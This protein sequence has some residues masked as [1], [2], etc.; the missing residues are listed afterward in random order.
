[1]LPFWI[2]PF[3]HYKIVGKE[4]LKEVKKTGVVITSNHVHLTDAPLLATRL[5]G[6]KRKV[7]IVMLSENMDIPVAGPFME[8]LGCV[9]LGDT[10]SGMKNFNAH[11]NSLLQKKKP[12]LIFP[13]TALWPYYRKIRPFSRGPFMFSVNNNVPIL[14]VVITFRTRKNGKQKMLVNI[15]KPIYPKDKNSKELLEEVQLVYQNFAGD[16]YKKYR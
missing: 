11:I 5:F 16:F 15:L 6:I 2:K 13:E 7:R 12:V 1:M 4:N 9:P 8:A 14:P 3:T 10:I